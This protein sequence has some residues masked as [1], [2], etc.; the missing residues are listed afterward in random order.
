MQESTEALIPLGDV[1]E[2]P[3]TT[4]GPASA[5]R[6][7][8]FNR[9]LRVA[10][11]MKGGIS[12]AVW[13][14][15]AV[16]ELDLLRR[17]RVL[18]TPEQP[19]PFLVRVGVDEPAA[20]LERARIYADLLIQARYD[21]VE[22]DVLAGA[23]AGG[24]NA[25][26]FGVSQRAGVAFDTV[27]H[28]WLDAGAVW[29]LLRK[30]WARGYTSVL[31]GD[32]FFAKQVEHAISELHG[33]PASDDHQARA[34]SVELSGTIV[35][36]DSSAQWGF[37]EGR[38]HF[39]FTGR[40]SSSREA[41]VTGAL[42]APSGRDIPSGPNGPDD[43]AAFRRLSYAARTTSSFPG[44]FEPARILSR[45]VGDEP[46]PEPPTEHIDFDFA[47][48]HHR[49]HTDAA[50]VEVGRLRPFR[51]IDG[52]VADNVPI[53]RALRAVREMPA[54]DFVS[55]AIL[56]L[57]PDPA[58]S[59][60][61]DPTPSTAVPP[62]VEV[63]SPHIARMI[64]NI[65]NGLG[66][67][68]IRESGDA[69]I[70]QV[71]RFRRERYLWQGRRESLASLGVAYERDDGRAAY[72]R[73]R[74]TADL[75]L[76]S[77]TLTDPALWQL[78]TD[79]PTRTAVPAAPRELIVAL[80]SRIFG[81]YAQSWPDSDRMAVPAGGLRAFV[82]E[83]IVRGPQAVL[84][85]A[86]SALAWLREIETI[87][88]DQ[89]RWFSPDD[90]ER[91][92]AAR[93]LINDVSAAARAGRDL[94]LQAA[95]VSAMESADAEKVVS[96]WVDGNL[97]RIDDAH[98]AAIDD[99][100][101]LIKQ[102]AAGL[103]GDE[104][105]EL[106]EDVPWTRFATLT[107][108][109]AG[110]D[111]VDLAPFTSVIGIPSPG[112]TLR[113]DVISAN[114]PGGLDAEFTAL[115]LAQA[116]ELA[117]KWMSLDDDA[118]AAARTE[119][120]AARA[121]E[122]LGHRRL[123]PLTKLAG[124]TLWSFG[125]FF[126]TR[127]RTNDWWWGHLDAAAGLL[128]ILGDLGDVDPAEVK[129]AARAAQQ[130][131]LTQA[132]LAADDLRPFD[133]PDSVA[134]APLRAHAKP[135]E[136]TPT[137]PVTVVAP[138]TTL[139]P[140]P[141]ADPGAAPSASAADPGAAPSAS[142]VAA[143]TDA[144]AAAP[145]VAADTDATTATTAT[146]A[147]ATADPPQATDPSP[148]PPPADSAARM[149]SGAHSLRNLRADY[150]VAV[151]SRASRIAL[152]AAATG[153]GTAGRL[154]IYGLLPPLL[155]NV[156]FVVVP[157]RAVFLALVFAAVIAIVASGHPTLA[158]YPDPGFWLGVVSLALVAAALVFALVRAA[159]A[160][161]RADRRR[162][163]VAAA[164]SAPLDDLGRTLLSALTQRGA[165]ARRVAWTSWSIG[166]GAL[167][168]AI[169]LTVV[170]GGA[171]V[172]TWCLAGITVAAII[173][174]RRASR[175]FGT[176]RPDGSALRWLLAGIAPVIVI[177]LSQPIAVATAA[178]P[179]DALVP[180]LVAAVGLIAAFTLTH[181]WLPAP[182]P[183]ENTQ[184]D[185]P[186][187]N[188]RPDA[189]DD[190]TQPPAQPRAAPPATSRPPYGGILRWLAVLLA[191]AAVSGLAAWLIMVSFSGTVI[192]AQP[193]AAGLLAWFLGAH[194]LWWL[195]ERASSDAAGV[196]DRPL[197]DA[198]TG[199]R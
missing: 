92:I 78:G 38:A 32:Q 191:T 87:V 113:F 187:E 168:V 21:Q 157:I 52:G 59:V 62:S 185:A 171:Q 183:G 9:S 77:D 198:L 114:E 65:R 177:I 74:E 184:P 182:K 95:L 64:D 37:Q 129:E 94:A 145:A 122:A 85:A 133:K 51:A 121:A 49:P 155:V 130:S 39:R 161:R 111:A 166:A 10:L 40:R 128:R 84:D 48:S 181:G 165:R 195:S 2:R 81:D 189:P 142:A 141:A 190:E 13:I 56:Y 60:P 169:V 29:N 1:G 93:R 66:L 83:A 61:R 20:V 101:A 68:G 31:D 137:A 151:A 53:D 69:E 17:I 162:A 43:P 180:A 90:E 80:E 89:H 197:D 125:A 107:D 71:E 7:P 173:T 172:G 104:A 105:A 100:I 123:A 117:E 106:T 19:R 50:D 12:L 144:T 116:S 79:L 147:A 174:A 150:L 30:P 192:L 158:P 55:R 134:E 102:L 119:F 138:A 44:A 152:R 132:C 127:W 24:L 179:R 18:G 70:D 196:D 86:A 26:L 148:L 176:P 199:S 45:P 22:F 3:E 36:A 112:S 16:A 4:D 164:A 175:Q 76:L 88:F 28:T 5:D 75:S 91:R 96:G 33:S 27:L 126:S 35:D 139:A 6:V 15:G 11:A 163:D 124:T 170:E 188:T 46:R 73:Y 146:A 149:T 99:A 143:D 63:R 167:L 82:A 72:I 186:D 159:L 34:V 156:P 110:V 154:A 58:T 42:P 118:L 136:P 97:T 178:W 115:Q 135:A 108:S 194:T 193:A 8:A 41:G 23:S 140:P 98:W 25:V 14:G 120:D 47:F 160:L 153:R 57:E 54:E 103:D 131:I 109:D 67:R